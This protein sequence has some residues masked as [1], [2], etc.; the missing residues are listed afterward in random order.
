MTA[1]STGTGHLPQLAA[2][3]WACTCGH[4]HVLDYGPSAPPDWAL[5]VAAAQAHTHT[6]IASLRALTR[7]L[8][9]RCNP[10]S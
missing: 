5:R 10:E 4:A 7:P 6:T 3:S 9:T 2:V 1:H 8:E